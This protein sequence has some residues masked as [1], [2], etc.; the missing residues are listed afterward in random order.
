MS[1]VAQV[2]A[3]VSNAS[4]IAAAYQTQL[5][6]AA[7]AAVAARHTGVGSEHTPAAHMAAPHHDLLHE[8]HSL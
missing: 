3:S 1:S 8:Y 6:L 4:A 5:S 7:A 2:P